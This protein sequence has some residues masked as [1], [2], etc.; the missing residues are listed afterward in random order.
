MVGLIGGLGGF[1]GPIIFGYLLNYTG[2][3]TSWW[4]FICLVSVLC[5]IWM[6]RTIISAMHNKS[7]NF[8]R[9]IEEN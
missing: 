2:L 7:P 3:W 4:I 9:E 6:H 8:K 1:L 5:L